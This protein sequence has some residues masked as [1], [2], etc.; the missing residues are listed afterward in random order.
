MDMSETRHRF[1]YWVELRHLGDGSTR[2][3][4]LRPI[5]R[6]HVPR[7][8]GELQRP[9]EVLLRLDD[10]TVILEAT[11]LDDV[12]AQLR[13][14]YPDS[15]YERSLHRERDLDAERAMD[16]LMRLL[17]RAVVESQLSKDALHQ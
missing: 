8:K 6:V 7:T 4:A 13:M 2:K 12:V 15:A 3:L 17:A 10:E 11:N 16:E 9:T 1:R 5:T 14:K